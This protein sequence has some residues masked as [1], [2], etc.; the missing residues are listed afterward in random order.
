MKNTLKI[1]VFIS[2][3][4]FSLN[5][6][7]QWLDPKISVGLLSSDIHESYIDREVEKDTT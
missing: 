1:F 5:S 2:S 6:Y 7:S 3:I 4:I